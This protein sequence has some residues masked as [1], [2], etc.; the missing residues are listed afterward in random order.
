[1]LSESDE[2]DDPI[3][4]MLKSLLDGHIVLSRGLAE[5][6]QFPAIDVARSVS[7]NMHRLIPGERLAQ[8][9]T[10]LAHLAIY[11]DSRTLIESGLYSKGSSAAI[12]AA[13]S[14][15]PAINAF[16]AQSMEEFCEFDQTFAKLAV[17]ADHKQ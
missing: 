3:C 7:R 11:E 2:V 10:V 15:L 17:V 16:L 1:M 9:R 5:R 13:I 4:E 12:D 6:G 14:A 8:S